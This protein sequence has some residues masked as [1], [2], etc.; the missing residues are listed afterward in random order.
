LTSNIQGTEIKARTKRITC[1]NSFLNRNFGSRE[2]R[3]NH[4]KER[5]PS[6]H[7]NPYAH[8]KERK[9][10][11]LSF[12]KIFII[13]DGTWTQKHVN[14]HVQ[15]AWGLN[16]R[17]IVYPLV[18]DCKGKISE[19]RLLRMDCFQ[20]EIYQANVFQ[21]KKE[22]RKKKKEKRKWKDLKNLEKD[23][24]RNELVEDAH[25]LFEENMIKQAQDNTEGHLNF[26]ILFV[27]AYFI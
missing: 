1:T 14:K 8:T 5:T 16:F 21:T 20:L 13:W 19:N 18:D 23:H 3:S 9:K 7:P 6:P 17:P 26:E 25:V 27:I 11:N 22:K 2:E 4:K 15:K 24:L 12:I 10:R